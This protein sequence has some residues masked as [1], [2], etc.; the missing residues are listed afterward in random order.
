MITTPYDYYPILIS[1]MGRVL[2]GIARLFS[3]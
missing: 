2:G 3:Q 1:Y